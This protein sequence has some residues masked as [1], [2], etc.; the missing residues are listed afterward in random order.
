MSEKNS[1]KVESLLARTLL[2]LPLQASQLVL[3]FGD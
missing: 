1:A 2:Q 3:A